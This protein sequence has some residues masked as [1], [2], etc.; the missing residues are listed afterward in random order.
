MEW[1]EIYTHSRIKICTIITAELLTQI[2]QAG[3]ALPKLRM[4][5]VPTASLI[6]FIDYYLVE[7]IIINIKRMLEICSY[8]IWSNWSTYHIGFNEAIDRK[9]GLWIPLFAKL[10]L[11][12]LYSTIQWTMNN[13]MQQMFTKECL[14]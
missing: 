5:L 7:I 1:T 9:L 11:H 2:N 10:S 6:I 12:Y 4:E 13:Q 8:T 14:N 3:D